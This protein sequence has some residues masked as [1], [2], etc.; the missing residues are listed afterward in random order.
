VGSL[1]LLLLAKEEAYTLQKPFQPTVIRS[2]L[3]D[4]INFLFTSTKP[5]TQPNTLVTFLFI[6]VFRLYIS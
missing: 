6:S 2:F 4:K 1:V 3:E 5:I